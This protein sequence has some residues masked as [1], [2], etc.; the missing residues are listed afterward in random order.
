LLGNSA[1]IERFVTGDELGRMKLGE[2]PFTP[3]PSHLSADL[4]VAQQ[5]PAGVD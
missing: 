3:A 5:V 2:H 4:G 1:G